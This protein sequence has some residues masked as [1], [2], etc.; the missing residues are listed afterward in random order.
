MVG[1]GKPVRAC[2]DHVKPLHCGCLGIELSEVDELRAATHPG[3]AVC[4]LAPCAARPLFPILRKCQRP[5]CYGRFHPTSYD[6][7]HIDEWLTAWADRLGLA[8]L[9][10]LIRSL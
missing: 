10:R 1:L 4:H 5:G 2:P 7:L 6:E 8:R 9:R 3:C